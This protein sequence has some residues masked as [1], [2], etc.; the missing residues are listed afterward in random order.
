MDGTAKQNGKSQWV[1]PRRPVMGKRPYWINTALCN[2]ILRWGVCRN[3]SVEVCEMKIHGIK[4][5]RTRIHIMHPERSEQNGWALPSPSLQEE[6]R[7]GGCQMQL[8]CRKHVLLVQHLL[9]LHSVL[10]VTAVSDFFA[11]RSNY[12]G[13]C[14]K[15]FS[16]FKFSEFVCS[17]D[18]CFRI[19]WLHLQQ[20]VVLFFVFAF[21]D[22]CCN[23]D[24]CFAF[25]DFGCT[26]AVSDC[27]C[28]Q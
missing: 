24:V 28:I 22:F 2:L 12:F 10:S 9:F 27:S 19:Q 15:Y 18:F 6:R 25:N 7:S 11:F 8:H 13:C 23:N 20:S 26:I 21:S 14:G 5:H 4:M 3:G 17:S 16:F 1:K